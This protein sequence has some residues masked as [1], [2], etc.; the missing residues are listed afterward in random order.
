MHALIRV[1]AMDDWEDFL[2]WELWNKSAEK[3]SRSKD[4][5]GCLYMLLIGWWIWIFKFAF[6]I[7]ATMLYIVARFLPF[8]IAIGLVLLAASI[9]I[10]FIPAAII[11][12]VIVTILHKK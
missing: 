1:K 2:I 12:V 6:S 3:D 9:G 4:S 11:V 8:V 7:M 5:P 10:V